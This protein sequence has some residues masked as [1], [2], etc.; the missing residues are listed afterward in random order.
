[1]PPASIVLVREADGD[2]ELL[3]ANQEGFRAGYEEATQGL[4]LQILEQRTQIANLQENTLKAICSQFEMLVEEVRLA[5]PALALDVARRT[6]AGISLDADQ[7]K[8]IASEALAELASGT[9]GI[10]LRLCPHDL[11]MVQDLAEEFAQKYP[12]LE[13][14][15]D[16]DLLSGDCLASSHFGTID[17]R[18]AGKLENIAHALL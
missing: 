3:V 10:K 16:P 11:R 17:A 2:Q 5:V 18:I 4:N 1:M 14:V 6:L 15:A 9:P 12:G 13:L 7:V 8:A